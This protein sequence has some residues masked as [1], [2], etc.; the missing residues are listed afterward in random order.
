MAKRLA[1]ILENGTPW[2]WQRYALSVC[3]FLKLPMTPE[4][5]P[6]QQPVTNTRHLSNLAGLRCK[7]L[8]GKDFLIF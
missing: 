4:S 1:R 8:A 6:K 5:L 2:T 7:L 3:L